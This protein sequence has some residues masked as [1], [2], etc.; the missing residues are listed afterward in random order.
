[1]WNSWFIFWLAK[2]S[3]PF[4]AATV[5][6]HTCSLAVCGAKTMIL[7]PWAGAVGGDPWQM[8][9]VVD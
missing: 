8:L 4:I 5:F 2:V 9:V 6:S 1:M 3:C 7:G